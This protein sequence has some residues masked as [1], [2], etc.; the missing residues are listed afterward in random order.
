MTTATS[1]PRTA[2][3]RVLAWLAWALL[4]DAGDLRSGWRVLGHLGLSAGSL[5]VAGLVGWGLLVWAGPD[6]LTTLG[7]FRFGAPF[8][9]LCGA[10]AL[11]HL[12]SGWLLD[13][14][15]GA[16]PRRFGT[17]RGV[18]L[19]PPL[20][21]LGELV[22]GVALGGALLA[23]ALGA[24]SLGGVRIGPGAPS[25]SGFALWTAMLFF[26]A[27]FEELFFRGYG[28]VWTAAALG[29]VLAWIGRLV[30]LGSGRWPWLIA[31]TII[32]ATSSLIF[33]LAHTSNHAA[34][35]LSFLNT[36]LAGIWLAVLVLQTR[37]LSWA[38]GA[39][40]GWNQAQILIFGVPVSGVSPET[41]GAPIPSL[42]IVT[43]L[44]PTWLTGG[45]YGPEASV[46]TTGALLVAMAVA[47]TLPRRA[48]DQSMRGLV[49]SSAAA[50]TAAPSA[51]S[52]STAAATST[53]SSS[54]GR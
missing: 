49:G 7:A 52:S 54:A 12:L 38:C 51:G 34:G 9:L 24:A 48:P 42:L 13:A 18:G 30:G 31:L 17:L 50:A 1:P 25:L 53:G 44:G 23:L 32:T 29:G 20:R 8:V 35:A 28:F 43:P 41:L 5:L 40:L 19:G 26:A 15:I 2:R 4:R 11:A 10:L 45:A 46:A 22:A 6:L 39:H 3:E 37:T 21:W 33:G 14:R 47:A 36:A 27:T 16:R